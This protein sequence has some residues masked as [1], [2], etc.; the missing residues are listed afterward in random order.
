[1]SINW[2]LISVVAISAVVLLMVAGALF[3]L[4]R[5]ARSKKT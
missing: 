5:W 2:I 3:W 1:M 4:V